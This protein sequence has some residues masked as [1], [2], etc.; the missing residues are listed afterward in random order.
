MTKLLSY[1]FLEETHLKCYPR[2]CKSSCIVYPRSYVSS[3]LIERALH[4]ILKIAF[5]RNKKEHLHHV[6]NKIFQL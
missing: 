3:V 1:T 4:Y 2:K 6:K 5:Y